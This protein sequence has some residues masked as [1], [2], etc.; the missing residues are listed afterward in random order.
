MARRRVLIAHP[1]ATSLLYPL[2]GIVSRMDVDLEFHTSLFFSPGDRI[3]RAVGL[4][5]GR[6]R[7]ALR[8]EVTVL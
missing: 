4:L 8:R 1:G 5:P 7:G 2:V 6:L 3:D